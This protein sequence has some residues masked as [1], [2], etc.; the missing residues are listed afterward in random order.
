MVNTMKMKTQ[1]EQ[2]GDSITNTGQ[3]MHNNPM[4]AGLIIQLKKPE[5]SNS[6]FIY[7]ISYQMETMFAAQTSAAGFLKEIFSLLTFNFLSYEK[8]FS[9]LRPPDLP[10]HG[11]GPSVGME[12]RRNPVLA[13]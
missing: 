1:T 5:K 9:H 12:R 8:R 13:S 2:A 3:A 11:Q 7:K 4:T 6:I 10:Q